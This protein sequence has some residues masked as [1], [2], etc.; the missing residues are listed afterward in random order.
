LLLTE[1]Y[2]KQHLDND[3]LENIKQSKYFNFYIV[4][5]KV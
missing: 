5:S 4:T 2:H 3:Y 1:A